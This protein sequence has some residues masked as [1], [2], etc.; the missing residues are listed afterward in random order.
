[1][2]GPSFPNH[3]WKA[4]WMTRL[5][6]AAE[7]LRLNEDPRFARIVEGIILSGKQEL[8][9]KLYRAIEQ[10]H[11]KQ[12]VEPDHFLSLEDTSH[13]E[14]LLGQRSDGKPVWIQEVDL[15]QHLLVAGQSGSGKTNFLA[16]LFFQVT[17][18]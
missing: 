8:A 12:Q 3:S 5:Q 11:V 2:S 13:G 6:T 7:S 4:N 17:G 9:R 15:C 1:M 18:L 10:R 16:F 14:I